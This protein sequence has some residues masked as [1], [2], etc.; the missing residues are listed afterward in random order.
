MA[1]DTKYCSVVLDQGVGYPLEY[2]SDQTLELGCRVKVP[3]RQRSVLGT[4]VEIYSDKRT[5]QP[6]PLLE[7]VGSSAIFSE[8]LYKLAQKIA[9]YWCTPLRKVMQMMLPKAVK[10]DV[11]IK[12]E[13]IVISLKGPK[14]LAE[15][16]AL[17]RKKSP[18]QALLLDR[19][20]EGCK[21]IP[22]QEISSKSALKGLQEKGL[23][24]VVD[25]PQYLEQSQFIPVIPKALSQEQAAAFEGIK[26]SL[27]AG[28]FATH[29]LYGITGSGKT[30][31]YI[32]LI[33]HALSMQKGVIVLVPEIALTEQ[34]I[35]RFRSRFGQEKMA[36]L[37]HRLSDGER[38]RYW[39]EIFEGKIRL[40][41]GARSAIFSPVQNLGLI[42]IDE[43]HTAA[44]K[45]S[46]EMPGYHAR[47]VAILRAHQLNATT[48]LG[49]ATPSFETYR[50][51]LSGKFALHILKQRPKSVSLPNVQLVD[52]SRDKEREARIFSS[53]LID[54]MSERLKK[55]EQTILFLNRR[56]YHSQLVCSACSHRIDCPHCASPLT[57]HRSK[58]ELLCHLCS[59]RSPPMKSCPTCQ[60]PT[61]KFRG[62]GTEQ[63][64][65]ALHAL[66]PDA[67]VLRIDADTT[68]EKGQHAEL[69]KQFA[70]GKADIL[71]G[72]QMVA[73]GLHFPHVTLVGVLNADQQLHIPDFR[74]SELTF[75]QLIQVAGRSGRGS[76]PGEVLLQT[77]QIDSP[78][79]AQA[80]KGD[81]DAFY[82]EEI[83]SRELFHYPPYTKAAKLL[84]RGPSE[85]LTLQFAKEMRDLII[86]RLPSS[87]TIYP[88]SPCGHAKVQDQFRFQFLIFQD[89]HTPLQRLV[90]EGILDRHLQNKSIRVRIDIDP[91]ST[92]F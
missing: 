6:H 11:S 87:A 54:K 79:I 82:H 92:Y 25:K 83:K 62:I 22:H 5:H 19:F 31:V 43:E 12:T 88:V 46:D 81:F 59:Y 74:S 33:E 34:T 18:A 40:V 44:Y 70:T 4:V 66:F 69:F 86:S 65:R 2:Q 56:G 60:S 78:V 55:G 76:L 42:V 51:A 36:L 38:N 21:A 1:G 20:L 24:Q 41:I 91:L 61:M 13:R 14:E 64:E 7:V 9:F 23:L 37:H 63:V 53:L 3:L 90:Q 48:L 80:L 67:R 73:K 52:M 26:R 29:L 35:E 28:T 45:Q 8:E 15:A 30:E 39:R 71:I 85:S 27:D 49:S 68:K 32:R 89:T 72:T 16:A 58:E 84:F 57:F 10:S 75:Q 17:Y 77:H 50:N 47:D